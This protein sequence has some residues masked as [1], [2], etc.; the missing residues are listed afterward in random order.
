MNDVDAIA[1]GCV[2]EWHFRPAPGLGNAHL[3]T[4]AGG[5]WPARPRREIVRERWE[6]P[7]GDFVDVDWFDDDASRPWALA[8]P[9]VA[10][11]LDSPYVVRLLKRL[12][13]AGYHAGL[14][15][16]RGMSGVPNRLVTAYHAGFSQDL[17]LV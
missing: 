11:N 6:L 15:N 3:Q 12:T 16:Y 13:A 10:G 9:G 8:L 2:R 4:L 7:D 1:H 14:L 17:D 5:L